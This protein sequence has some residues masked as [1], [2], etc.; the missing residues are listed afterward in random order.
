MEYCDAETI[1]LFELLGVFLVILKIAIP[2]VIV[3]L[4]TF[5]YFKAVT[6]NKD[7]EI[8]KSTA[9]L[10]RRIIAGVIIFFIPGLVNF[11]FGLVNVGTNQC[12]SCALDLKQCKYVGSGNSQ[13]GSSSGSQSELC[14]M[15][16]KSCLSSIL[17]S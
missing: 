8:K 7:D 9:T 12:F 3:I 10:I 13:L 16:N 17:E 6:G 1:E 15:D 5:D 2:L 14:T 4:G 11:I